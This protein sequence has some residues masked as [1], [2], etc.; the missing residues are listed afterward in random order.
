MNIFKEMRLSIYSFKSYGEFLKNKKGKVFGFG[1]ML[2]V[3][4]F[5]ITMGVPVI[6]FFG[7]ETISY[8]IEKT[9]PDF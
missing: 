7:V 9:V 3:I 1:V 4:Y 6:R 5:L 2:M 8:K